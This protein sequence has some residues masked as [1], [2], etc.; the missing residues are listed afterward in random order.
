MADSLQTPVLRAEHL[1][2][3]GPYLTCTCND[4]LHK[5]SDI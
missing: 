1:R 3:V 4:Y 5:S 2:K